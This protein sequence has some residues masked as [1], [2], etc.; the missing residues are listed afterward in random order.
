[1]YFD[2]Q[3]VINL[4]SENDQIL[5]AIQEL[6]ELIQ[7]LGQYKRK[8]KFSRNNLISEIADVNICLEQI[9]Y[10]FKIKKSEIEK[11]INFKT[12]RFINKIKNKYGVNIK[13]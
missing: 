8:D 13:I 1:M 5:M 11:F 7:E 6:A 12:N 10:I 9:K 3:K 2:Y 4:F